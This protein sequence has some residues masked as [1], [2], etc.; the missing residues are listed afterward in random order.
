MHWEWVCSKKSMEVL[1]ALSSAS[2]PQ[3][4]G[5]VLFPCNPARQEAKAKEKVRPHLFQ[6]SSQWSSHGV[7]CCWRC[8]PSP[9]PPPSLRSPSPLPLQPLPALLPPSPPL[10]LPM[11]L[12]KLRTLKVLITLLATISSHHFLS[13]S[14]LLANAT[15]VQHFQRFSSEP[16]HLQSSS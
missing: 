12:L 4:P 1:Y 6:L 14:V 9:P 7:P 10:P 2:L 16:Q 8:S 3:K 11:R 5:A 15:S 13:G